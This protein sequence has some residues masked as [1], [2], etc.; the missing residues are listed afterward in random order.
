MRRIDDAEANGDAEATLQF[1][2]RHQVASGMSI[3]IL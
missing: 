2:K 1:V 3:A